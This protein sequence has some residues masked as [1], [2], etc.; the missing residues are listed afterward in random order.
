MY[1]SGK[2][3]AHDD[4][5]AVGYHKLAAKQGNVSAQER[6][7]AMYDLAKVSCKKHWK[8]NKVLLDD[9]C[10]LSQYNLAHIN[11]DGDR[12]RQDVE[13]ADRFNTL[14]AENG[15]PVTQ[16]YLAVRSVR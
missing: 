6:L 9:G 14:A 12:V 5:K 7:G 11:Y 1:P 3:V 15:S 4:A 13:Q 10:V 8:G 16:H 2:G